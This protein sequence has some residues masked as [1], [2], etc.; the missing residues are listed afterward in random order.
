MFGKGQKDIPY[1]YE[2]W[3]QVLGCYG[4]RGLSNAS[5][6][7][8]AIFRVAEAFMSR[9]GDEYLAG[10]WRKDLIR[11]LLWFNLRN[12]WQCSLPAEYRAPSWSW[13]S[14]DCSILHNDMANERVYAEIIE[15]GC[16]LKGPELTGEV[17]DGWITISGPL[18]RSW[19]HLRAL[20]LTTNILS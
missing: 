9:L 17:A 10:L 20:I 11:G 4:Y 15:E 16:K 3:R 2:Q 6:K 14:V 5:D 19:V 12:F 7:L 8:P 13:A 1:L 18:T